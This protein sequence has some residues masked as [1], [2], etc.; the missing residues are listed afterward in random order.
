MTST[1]RKRWCQAK[2][3]RIRPILQTLGDTRR[4]ACLARPARSPRALRDLST[5]REAWF[6]LSKCTVARDTCTCG[7]FAF[8]QLKQIR[9][10]VSPMD[11][12]ASQQRQ[13]ATKL[14]P[15][16]FLDHRE[17]LGKPRDGEKR[18]LEQKP[19][20][21]GI[22]RLARSCLVLCV[23]ADVELRGPPL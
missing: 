3:A 16:L 7:F 8:L 6:E 14:S 10:G 13:C 4:P 22:A 20:L 23:T 5:L 18:A 15:A 19:R 12:L 2:N 11:A 17:K 9:Q 21:G 1:Y